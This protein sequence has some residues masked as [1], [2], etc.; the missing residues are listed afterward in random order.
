MTTNKWTQRLLLLIVIGMAVV[1]SFTFGVG[2]SE[3]KREVATA[4]DT[5]NFDAFWQAWQIVN[6]KFV[7]DESKPK[8]SD[9][10]KVYGAI[11][12][13]VHSLGDPYSEFLPPEENKV[14]S[15]DIKGSFGG[16]GVEIGV[17][18]GRLMVI[19]P[20][21]G[22]P[23]KAAGI[24][25]GDV[26]VE[27]EGEPVG[28][29][30]VTEATN[31][32]RGQVGTVVK[33]GVSHEGEDKVE[34][35]QIKRDVI[36]VPTIETK[37]LANDIYLIKLF[38][39]GATSPNLFRDAL[40]D[41]LKTGRN[42]LILDMRGNPGGYLD[43]AVSMASWFLPQGETVVIEDRGNKEQRKLYASRGYDVFNGHDLRMVILVDS[44]TASAAEI[45]AGALH[46]HGVAKLVGEQTFGKGSVQELIDLTDDT[47]LKI[48]V[49]HWLTPQGISISSN[50]LKPDVVVE[51]PKDAP[52]EP[53]GDSED[54]ILQ[55]GI[56]TVLGK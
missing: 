16:I 10:D 11:E 48:T 50:G 4:P 47:S 8:I 14:F 12:G 43:A 39:F 25:A 45:L 1:A 30:T 17:R 28:K 6:D 24:K 15:Q 2:W 40:R 53:K 49:A 52:A 33:V 22:S 38:N 41:F 21:E 20:I 55:Q 42:H 19:T 32:I 37:V 56:K 7:G 46:E 44:G 27:I 23:A 29:M 9:Q 31:K 13:L 54:L 51:L 18:G 35:F 3:A 5:L 26:I 34:Q 36:K